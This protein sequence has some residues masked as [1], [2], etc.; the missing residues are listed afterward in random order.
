[1]DIFPSNGIGA[2][3]VACLMFIGWSAV[4]NEALLETLYHLIDLNGSAVHSCTL[5]HGRHHS[6]GKF[7]RVR[8][9]VGAL[10]NAARSS[11][12]R[13]SLVLSGPPAADGNLFFCGSIEVHLNVVPEEGG[14]SLILGLRADQL[15]KKVF[16]T[17]E[18]ILLRLLRS[19]Y[20]GRFW[21]PRIAGPGYYLV[22]LGVMSKAHSMLKDRVY[23]QRLEIW[24][25]NLDAGHVPNRGYLREVYN[26][27]FL[28]DAHERRF[29]ERGIWCDLARFGSVLDTASEVILWDITPGRLDEARCFFERTGLVL[30][31]PHFVP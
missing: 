14:S 8:S 24:R 17:T 22:G 31:S 1:M 2:P 7:S 10:M 3:P 5:H 20:G 11:D 9:T 18:D 25:R 21:M 29:T 13:L 12:E 30:S 6:Q 23:R 26:A 28:T 4:A 16:G 19:S 27:N 15:H